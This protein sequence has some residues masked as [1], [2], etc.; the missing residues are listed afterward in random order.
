[1]THEPETAIEFQTC[2]K[3][4]FIWTASEVQV[5]VYNT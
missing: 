5:R 2:P 4:V 1:M 3:Q